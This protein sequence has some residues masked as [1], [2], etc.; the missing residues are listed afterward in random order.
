MVY[1]LKI[2]ARG[3]L[4]KFIALL[5]IDAIL[6]GSTGVASVSSPILIIGF[7]LLIAT[8]FY[9]TRI[10]LGVI[11]FYGVKIK[12]PRYLALCI[13]GVMGSLLAL[14]SVGELNAREIIVLL[15]LGG[16]TYL[17][18]SYEATHKRSPLDN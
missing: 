1:V 15:M 5:L 3:Y 13:S 18:S 14:Q 17:Y 8:I 6:F 7:V 11:G 4:Q 9:F 10:I 16:L 2:L 12:R